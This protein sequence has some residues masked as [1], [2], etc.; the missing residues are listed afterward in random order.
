[1]RLG[2]GYA[3][4]VA[5]EDDVEYVEE[6]VV[7]RR[8]KG[9][10]RSRSRATAG[11]DRDLLRRDGDLLGPTE[12]RPLNDDDIDQLQRHSPSPVPAERSFI[13]V[14][15]VVPAVTDAVIDFTKSPEFQQLLDAGW[16]ATSEQLA[17]ARSWTRQK[18]R[19]LR[20]RV[21]SPTAIVAAHSSPALPEEYVAEGTDVDAPEDLDPVSVRDYREGLRLFVA[22]GLYAA[23][24]RQWLASVRPDDE[25]LP[26]EVRDA[27]KAALERPISSLGQDTLSV[28]Y[29]FLL[30]S[31][32]LDGEPMVLRAERD[33]RSLPRVAQT[34]QASGPEPD[35]RPTADPS[36]SGAPDDND[37]VEAEQN[38]RLDIA[39]SPCPA[40]AEPDE[41]PVTERMEQ[42]VQ[43]APPLTPEQIARLRGLLSPCPEG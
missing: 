9:A 23:Q 42:L 10:Q 22:A 24:L 5:D 35:A 18:Y 40:H 6:I 36:R 2:W 30:Q 34:N 14:D 25:T 15:I 32:S 19:Q 27:A 33:A 26:Q 28:L 1:M 12:S 37:V 38:G 41:E 7:Q 13:M 17:R 39:A 11:Y 16:S 3:A 21:A 8:P 31:D 20:G 29:D 43:A 4:N